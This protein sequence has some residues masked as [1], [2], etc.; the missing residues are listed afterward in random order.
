MPIFPK[1]WNKLCSLDYP[2]LLGNWVIALTVLVAII[3]F[4]LTNSKFD[5]PK[6]LLFYSGLG[7][8]SLLWLLAVKKPLQLTLSPLLVILGIFVGVMALS[9]L[10]SVQ[11]LT[12]MVGLYFRF[13]NGLLMW[14]GLLWL[15]VMLSSTQNSLFVRKMQRAL[16]ITTMGISF[17]AILQWLGAD[18]KTFNLGTARATS[19]LGEPTNLAGVLAMGLILLEYELLLAKSTRARLI[20][21]AGIVS[22]VAGLFLTYTRSGEI[23]AGLG[24][25]ALFVAAWHQLG[26]K[27]LPWKPMLVI[28]ASVLIILGGVWLN[29]RHTQDAFANNRSAGTID[30]RKS[31]WQQIP[32][33]IMAKP[34][35]GFGPETFSEV[36]YLYRPNSLNLLPD[37]D[38][39]ADR[40]HNEYLQILVTMGLLGFL[41][42]ATFGL[43]LGLGLW[44]QGRATSRQQ[45]LSAAWL[46][47]ALL[48][49]YACHIFF[50]FSTI[51][52][53]L[54]LLPAV[55]VVWLAGKK[56]IIIVLNQKQWIVF[57]VVS[58][59]L[60]LV[61]FTI[62]GRQLIADMAENRAQELYQQQQYA[63]ALPWFQKAASANLLFDR[64]AR[65]TADDLL[66]MTKQNLTR[67][68]PPT[69]EQIGRLFAYLGQAQT[70][71]RPGIDNQTTQLNAYY[72]L[73]SG[74]PHDLQLGLALSD[75]LIAAAPTTLLYREY[76]ALFLLQSGQSEQGR[77]ELLET[78]RMKPDFAAAQFNLMI[79]YGQSGENEEARKFALQYLKSNP[80]NPVAQQFAKQL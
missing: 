25:L 31:I 38:K 40:A 65:Q 7:V 80:D 4:P 62:I 36:F 54:W 72:V 22:A 66:A 2:L 44:Q 12:S 61:G 41:A 9:T 68:L 18:F 69:T 26:F 56:T 48:G 51:V 43:V 16:A 20:W 67:N 30:I 5:L 59:G 14:L 15:L 45:E 35:L 3:F 76:R 42:Y 34:L 63:Q 74:N 55:L 1:L 28:V 53:D 73:S 8:A 29:A 77:A 39:N 71:N 79:S 11:P 37:W 64:Y 78:L 13:D 49:V 52:M 70:I 57:G 60:I 50:G 19:T 58:I 10:L 17:Y 24:T 46:G 47:M 75:R 23:A 27:H 32:A 21:A 33:M 6:M